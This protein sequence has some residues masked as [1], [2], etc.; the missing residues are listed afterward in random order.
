MNRP[1]AYLNTDLDLVSAT[2]LTELAAALAAEG[3][4]VLH[5]EQ[6]ESGEWQ[7]RLE[8]NAQHQ[9]TE[10]NI[11]AILAIVEGLP[12]TLREVWAGCTRRDFSIGFDCGD[13]PQ[14]VEHGLASDTLRR[15]A[16]AGAGLSITLY[17]PHD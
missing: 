15:L 12:Q 13:Q 8:T 1:I 7:A 14:A 4:F 16:A 3:M 5:C 2:A 6:Q 17:A 11:L 10:P 9:A